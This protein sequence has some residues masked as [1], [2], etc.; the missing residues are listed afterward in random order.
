MRVAVDVIPRPRPG[1]AETRQP[2]PSGLTPG[3]RNPGKPSGFAFTGGAAGVSRNRT[4]N[5]SGEGGDAAGGADQG[6]DAEGEEKK[7][8]ETVKRPWRFAGLPSFIGMGM[9]PG[10]G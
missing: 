3:T 7:K 6:P 9:R 2:E 4:E 1:A 10:A 8:G 5:A